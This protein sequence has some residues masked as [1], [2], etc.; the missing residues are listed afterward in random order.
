MVVILAA[1]IAAKRGRGDSGGGRCG[2]ADGSEGARGVTRPSR[3]STAAQPVQVTFSASYWEMM[4]TP[5]SLEA[6]VTLS[7]ARITFR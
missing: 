5:Q 1:R 7:P 3:G 6:T 4:E 2:A